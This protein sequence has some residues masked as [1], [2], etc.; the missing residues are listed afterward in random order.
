VPQFTPTQRRILAVLSDGLPHTP[1]ELHACLDDELAGRNAVQFHLSK[2][3]KTLREVGQDVI[4]E[5]Y[6]RRFTY[7]H[8]RLLANGE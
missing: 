8:V 5:Y 6:Q 3:R 2:L 4:C 7:R 1:G